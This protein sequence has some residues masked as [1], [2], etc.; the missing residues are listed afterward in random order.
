SVY[1]GARLFGGHVTFV[2]AD[3]GHIAGVVNPPAADKYRYWTG[4]EHPPS[5]DD[6]LYAAEEHAGSWWPLWAEWLKEK[7]GGE[8]DPPKTPK[9]AAAAPGEY[10]RET[11]TSIRAK[12]GK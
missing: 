1:K 11:L 8:V 12:R 4:D 2:L 6:W 3:S 5:S 10:V 7:S 9:S